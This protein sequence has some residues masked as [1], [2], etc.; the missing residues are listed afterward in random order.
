MDNQRK[1]S[2]IKLDTREVPDG[3]TIGWAME[4]SPDAVSLLLVQKPGD[5]R[6]P[7]LWIRLANGDLLLGTFPR[8]E[9][10]EYFSEGDAE[11]T[12]P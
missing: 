11:M 4:A 7:W 3:D 1:V 8:A 5:H 2:A 9:M 12:Y 6:S 10:Y